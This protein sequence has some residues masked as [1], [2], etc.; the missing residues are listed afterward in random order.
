MIEVFCIVLPD[1]QVELRVFF[2]SWIVAFR[3]LR[4]LANIVTA[5]YIFYGNKFLP[6]SAKTFYL[7]SFLLRKNLW[8]NWLYSH[9]TFVQRF[10]LK[11]YECIGLSVTKCY[12]KYL[13]SSPINS[14]WKTVLFQKSQKCLFIPFCADI[15][16]LCTHVS[17]MWFCDAICGSKRRE[18]ESAV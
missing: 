7:C 15:D 8:I 16:I 6:Y 1:G 10:F 11:I 9:P 13:N 17:E 18:I 12:Y 14:W 2:K 3:H 5:I 4:L